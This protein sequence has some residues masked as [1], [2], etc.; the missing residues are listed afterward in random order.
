MVDALTGAYAFT[1]P[2]R[3]TVRV[4]LSAFRA[5]ERLPGTAHP[6]LYGVRFACPCGDEHAALVRHDELDWAPLGF[7]AAGTFVNLMTARHDDLGE[8]LASLATARIGRGEW[9]WSF[10]CSLEDRARP[11]TPSAFVLLSP[12]GC[13]GPGRSPLGVAV[14][15][16]GCGAVSVNLVSPDHVDVPFRHDSTVG[17][18]THA[19]DADH[20]QTTEQLA[21]ELASA[22]FDERRLSL[23]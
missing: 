20:L 4:R 8:E 6:A 11:V 13:P 22:T 5:L 7:A 2:E 10:Y 21:G 19:F 23:R 12:C 15:C 3:G 9:P 14:L 16:P 17:V 1:C 18:A